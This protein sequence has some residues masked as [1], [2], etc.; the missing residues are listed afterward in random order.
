M[1]MLAQE[2]FVALLRAN[3]IVQIFPLNLSDG[4]QGV[5]AITAGR[6][7][8]Q[9]E[10]VGVDRRLV[11]LGVKQVA[12][13]AV[14]NGGLMECGGDFCGAWGDQVYAAIRGHHRRV[15]FQR[16][17]LFRPRLER[18]ALRFS[19]IELG[20]GRITAYSGISRAPRH[21]TQGNKAEAPEKN[22]QSR[23]NCSGSVPHGLPH[24]FVKTTRPSACTSRKMGWCDPKTLES[25]SEPGRK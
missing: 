25:R 13:R 21:T 12:H 6:I 22:L 19:A 24:S 2:F 18:L 1:R 7:F 16:A 9:E 20:L 4:E 15:F 10:Q 5:F 3:R 11:I 8:A 23:T 14:E 17:V